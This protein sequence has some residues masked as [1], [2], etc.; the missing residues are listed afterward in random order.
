ND[1]F[2]DRG[3]AGPDRRLYYRELV[4]RFAHHPAWVWNLGEENTQSPAQLAACASLLRELD[5]YNHPIVVHNDHWHAKNL[6]ETYRPLLG[7]GVIDGVSLQDF[8]VHDAPANVDWAV[9][10]STEAGRPWVVSVDEADGPD[11]G[12][13][14]DR[15]DPSR[16]DTRRLLWETLLAGGAGVEW[17]FGWRNNSPD[18]DLSAENWRSRDTLFRQSAIA[19]EFFQ[20][21]NGFLDLTPADDVAVGKGVSCLASPGEQYIVYLPDGRGTRLRL[22]DEP[23]LYTVRWFNPRQGGGLQTGPTSLI[24]GPGL[25]WTGPPPTAVTEDWVAVVSRTEETAPDSM[26]F[27]SAAWESASPLELGVDPAGLGHAL[28]AYRSWLRDDGVERVAISRRGVLIHEGPRS[29]ESSNV[30]SCTKSVTSTVLGLLVGDGVATLETPAATFEPLLI[31]DYPGV[32]LRHFATMTSGYSAQGVSRWGESSDDWS[33]TPYQ[34]ANPLFEPGKRYAYWDEAQMMFGRVLTHAAGEDLLDFVDRRIFQP[35]DMGEVQWDPEGEVNNRPIRNGCTGLHLNARQFAR[36]GHLILND[37]RW[38][39]EQVLPEG[40]VTLATESHVPDST[41]VAD[42]DRAHLDGRG[43]YGL[44]WWTNGGARAMPDA[45]SGAYYASGLHHN[46][47]LII[48]EW[49]MVVVRLGEDRSP[50]SVKS[51]ALNH[52]LRRLGQAVYPLPPAID[53]L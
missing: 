2:L 24:R 27:P 23:A 39:D 32:T 6:Q 16:D 40:W 49:E 18:S 5:P 13:V 8:F 28:D 47:C 17:Y 30:Y 29:S 33:S 14:A 22:P 3:E 45:P 26:R 7:R 44:N 1:H 15:E 48:P 19:R 10:A 20:R 34:P 53:S 4:S 42:T 21:G 31:A 52:F 41:P 35:L 46:V 12:A 38:R 37:G 11:R 50:T 43:C 9:R 51:K 25:G 36:F